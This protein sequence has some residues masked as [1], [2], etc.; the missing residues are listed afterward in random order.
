MDIITPPPSAATTVKDDDVNLSTY[1]I[2]QVDAT[3]TALLLQ[4]YDLS[5]NCVN[6]AH[7]RSSEPW[8]NHVTSNYTGVQS[9]LTARVFSND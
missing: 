5:D 4:D 1:G 7:T 3:D 6:M 2:G 9:S 8:N